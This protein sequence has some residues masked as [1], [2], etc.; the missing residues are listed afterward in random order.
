MMNGTTVKWGTHINKVELKQDM[1]GRQEYAYQ[2]LTFTGQLCLLSHS[3]NITSW[4][5]VDYKIQHTSLMQHGSVSI[6]LI[7]NPRK[8]QWTLQGWP[9]NL[10]IFSHL[11]ILLHSY[12]TTNICK[13]ERPPDV[14]FCNFQLKYWTR[15]LTI[16]IT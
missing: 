4:H 6:T 8:H 5:A 15:L 9:Y 16:L 14:I 3:S 7:S 10:H 11:H 1:H 13:W 12:V 2:P